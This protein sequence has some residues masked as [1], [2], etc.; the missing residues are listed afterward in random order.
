MKN[1]LPVSADLGRNMF[2]V[3]DETGQLQYGQVFVQYTLN[4]GG[5]P[6][7]AVN[8]KVLTGMT[9]C[10][11]IFDRKRLCGGIC[12][13]SARSKKSNRRTGRHSCTRCNRYR[14]IAR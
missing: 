12:R 9:E 11:V 7:S 14:R 6:R 4:I 2:G 13:S 8:R 3:I 5:N 10:F 1:Q